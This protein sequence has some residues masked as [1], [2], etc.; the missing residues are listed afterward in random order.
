MRTKI[1]TALLILALSVG[2]FALPAAA[3]DETNFTLNYD[4][5][6]QTVT[7]EGNGLTAGA[8]LSLQGFVND[9]EDYL[10]QL[11]VAEDGTVSCTYPSNGFANGDTLK[12]IIGGA[13]LS[14]P[15]VLTVVVQVVTEEI[16]RVQEDDEHLIFSGGWTE[17]VQIGKFDKHI[18]KQANKKNETMSFTFEGD[19]FRLISYQSYSQCRFDLY[20][21]GEKIENP[22]A[23]TDPEDPG[24]DP[25]KSFDLYEKGADASFKVPVAEMYLSHGVHTVTVIIVGKHPKSVGYNMY[26][27]AVEIGGEFVENEAD[28]LVDDEVLI[29]SSKAVS[30]DVLSNDNVPEGTQL[31]DIVFEQPEKGTVELKNGLLVYTPDTLDLSGDSFTYTVGDETATVNLVYTGSIRYEE[32]FV[33]DGLVFDNN[34]EKAMKWGNYK[35]AAYSGGSAKRSSQAGDTVTVTF[36]GSAIEVIGYMS[37]SRGQ[38]KVTLDGE[39]V[40]TEATS[41][42]DSYDVRYQWPVFSAE[43]LDE[44][45]H[46]LI[47]EV[48]GK[49]APK[50]L[51]TAIDIDAFVVTK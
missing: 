17:R 20:V 6:A 35:L 49:R 24:Y 32:T 36:Y 5:A 9:A 21:D 8:F 4:L 27:D 29:G 23:I 39:I 40:E 41:Y 37:K 2:I 42:H 19:Y 3:A 30:F 33:S 38:F 48:L 1:L 10:D 12:V 34:A 50:A 28:A 15:V 31:A 46:T 14:E 45:Q 22:D 13:D 44:T 47:I 51:G 18:A 11:T 26:L 16:Q 7:V 43:G 25:G